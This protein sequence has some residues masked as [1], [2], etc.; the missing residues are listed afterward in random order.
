M[1]KFKNDQGVMTE[2]RVSYRV[3]GKDCYVDDVPGYDYVFEIDD[4][5]AVRDHKGFFPERHTAWYPATADE[6]RITVG[7]SV[8]LSF[9]KGNP[10]GEDHP[11]GVWR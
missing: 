5:V 8:E 6:A 1:R 11:C 9:H 2:V 4:P 3:T 7:D 10:F